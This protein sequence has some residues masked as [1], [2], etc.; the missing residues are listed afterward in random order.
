M[1]VHETH[2]R[3]RVGSI[4]DAKYALAARNTSLIRRSSAFSFASR[5]FSSIIAVVGRSCGSPASASACRIQFRSASGC[6]FS[7][8]A[9]RRNVGRGSDW[10]CQPE[11]DLA[12]IS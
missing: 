7:C 4:S 1:R 9:S 6:T 8:S 12:H 2:D 11:L 10:L 5:R 3:L